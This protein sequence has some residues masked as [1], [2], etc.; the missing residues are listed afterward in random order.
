MNNKKTV[1][2]NGQ[3]YTFDKKTTGIQA[4][5]TDD[6]GRIIDAGSNIR[7]KP[8]AKRGFI[9]VDLKNKCVIPGM[10]DSH[11]HMLSLGRSFR[12]VDLDG[13]DSLE[14]VI[15]IVK[16]A[17]AIL[18]HG[19]WL[20]GRGWNKNL[21]GD[22]FPDKSIL[23]NITSHPVVLYSKDGHLTWVNSATLAACG[24]TSFTPN[25]P[26]GIIVKDKNNEPTGIVKE[27]ATDLID[28]NIPRDSFEN[29]EKAIVD[30]QKHLLKLGITGI[31]DCDGDPE[32]FSIYH[33]LDCRNRLHLRV[34]KMVSKNN[35][36]RA[37]DFKFH[38]GFGT[39]HFR[40]GC[41]KL[42][43]DGA[44]GSQTAYMFIPY[45]KSD[46][47]YG[48]EAMTAKEIEE[49]AGKAVDAG[50]SL[51]IHAIG[52]KANYQA[53]SAIGKYSKQIL[54]RDLRPRI[55]HAQ[56]LRKADIA[57]F[58]RY[59]IIAS[60]Q[61][62]HATSDRDIADRYWGKRSRYAYPF[63]TFLKTHTLMAFGSDAPI[64]T[65]DPLQGIYAAV[66][67]RR[68]GE[69]RSSWYPEERLSVRQAVATYTRGSAYASHF[70]D[71]AGSISIG[72]Q[73]DFVVLSDNIF[74]MKP[75]DVGS[76]KVLSTIIDGK[77]VSGKI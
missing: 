13:V 46:S 68:R 69:E 34:F 54:K 67:R 71:L 45:E 37:I 1:F 3:F 65:A 29:K 28:D 25:P 57:L 8:L 11:L 23:D 35:L 21:W 41:L 66:T 19:Q 40:V 20:M 5:A 64:E 17:A 73:A 14:K 53:L 74:E 58:S 70:E 6:D 12:R 39:D 42:F 18:P 51:A 61:P 9:P 62:I 30:A 60:V 36:Q 7:L 24:I 52:D 2:L 59:G 15:S 50:I 32:L 43:A 4:L 72:R 31:G 47:N 27:N 16:K 49:Y 10:I 56:V 55:E 76:V 38:T 26:G 22:D 33:D 44:L 75:P 63:K 48:V 77:L